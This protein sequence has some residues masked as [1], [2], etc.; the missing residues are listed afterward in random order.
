MWDFQGE[1]RECFCQNEIF[2]QPIPNMTFLYALTLSGN[3]KNSKYP[4]DRVIFH[5][6]NFILSKSSF[7]IVYQKYFNQLHEKHK[8]ITYLYSPLIIHTSNVKCNM[9]LHHAA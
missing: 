6:S 1:L 3:F 5:S 7:K 2:C 9:L 8:E 4:G